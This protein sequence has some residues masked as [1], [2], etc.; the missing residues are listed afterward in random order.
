MDFELLDFW[1]LDFFFAFCIFG[2][3][4]FPFLDFGIFDCFVALS[5]TY[6]SVH[7]TALLCALDH[8]AEYL[9]SAKTNDTIFIFESALAVKSQISNS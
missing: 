4:R 8:Y 3:S 9:Y 1:I 5:F 7:F 6:S 2:F